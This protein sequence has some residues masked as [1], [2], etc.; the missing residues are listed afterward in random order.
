LRCAS[1]QPAAAV[2]ADLEREGYAVH[3]IGDHLL[4]VCVT[5]LNAG[6]A[7]GLVAA[8]EEVI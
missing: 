1:T 2:A 6:D 5:D 8:F 3:V 4:Q 7:D